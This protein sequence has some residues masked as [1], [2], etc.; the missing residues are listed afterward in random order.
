MSICYWRGSFR[1]KIRKK[2]K[3][4]EGGSKKRKENKGK[5]R[6]IEL[7]EKGGEGWNELSLQLV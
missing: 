4:E 7:G 2:E 6:R 5:E 1:A 3:E